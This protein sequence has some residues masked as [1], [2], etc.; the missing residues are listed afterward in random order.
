M[1]GTR[2]A[3]R[4]NVCC[5][6]RLRATVSALLLVLLGA[7]PAAT[8]DD[9]TVEGER[10][11]LQTAGFEHMLELNRRLLRVSDRIRLAGVSLCEGKVTPV[12]GLMTAAPNALP[13]A[14]R[15]RAEQA[16]GEDDGV[17]VLAVEPGSPA[18][19]A[20]IVAGDVVLALASRTVRQAGDLGWRE[21]V[22]SSGVVTLRVKTARGTRDVPV[23][24]AMGCVL[25]PTLLYYERPLAGVTG[26]WGEMGLATGMLRFLE[27]DDEL[28]LVI[29]HELAHIVLETGGFRE[30][31]ADAD[32]LGAYLAAR[33][34]Y[35]V[36]GAVALLRRMG[37]EELMVLADAGMSSHPMPTQRF[38]ALEQTAREIE[39]KRAR[40]EP[41]AP[42]DRE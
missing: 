5:Y 4:G 8:G 25:D 38:V 2:A 35:D 36:S 28:A 39:G 42:K 22:H 23:D 24:V 10:T 9:V 1:G 32:H 30:T 11:R 3:V 12:W 6:S 37:R 19:R 17:F 34:G 41:L 18:A 15:M 33:A 14:F 21:D 40:G 16:V 13:S 29:G 26:N 7:Q 20:G 27:T 31:E